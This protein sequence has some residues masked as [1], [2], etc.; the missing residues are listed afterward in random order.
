MQK[1]AIRKLMKR[2]L[3]KL[4]RNTDMLLFFKTPSSPAEAFEIS[5]LRLNKLKFQLQLNS[6]LLEETKDGEERKKLEEERKKL[7]NMLADELRNGIEILDILIPDFKQLGLN[8][9]A[10][11]LLVLR[12]ARESELLE[13]TGASS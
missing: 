12:A 6:L 7:Q 11:E 10:D 2:K 13:L 9:K 5:E 3:R 4:I 1:E 8:D